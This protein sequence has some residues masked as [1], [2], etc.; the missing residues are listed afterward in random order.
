[1]AEW[2]EHHKLIGAEH[3]YIFD[4]GS[5]DNT[6]EVLKPYREAGIVTLVP[7][8][9]DGSQLQAYQFCLEAYGEFN[10]WVAFIDVDEFIYSPKGFKVSE[11]LKK[12]HTVKTAGVAVHWVVFG[13]NG[14]NSKTEG[15]VTERFTACSNEVNPHVKSIVRPEFVKSVGKNP[16]TF[17]PK[18]GKIIVN[19]RGE[20]MPPNYA[21]MKDGT[22]N[23]LR[24]NHYIT[25][26]L[27]EYVERKMTKPDAA[28][29]N[30]YQ[31]ERVEE[32]FRAHDCNQR[33][34]YRLRD[35]YL[36]NIKANLK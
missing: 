30:Y 14:H 7:F 28:T 22:A 23:I 18:E 20:T 29:A 8:L 16:H 2:V 33:T 26:S 4:N 17:V 19:E 27:G 1:M 13:S 6:L 15:L 3:F 21:I 5:T 12:F 31:I 35:L 9:G 11:I 10:T 25:K 32:M 34:D 24:I 36:E